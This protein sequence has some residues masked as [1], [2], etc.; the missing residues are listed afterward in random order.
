MSCV[1][2]SLQMSRELQEKAQTHLPLSTQATKG[3]EPTRG[4]RRSLK[5]NKGSAAQACIV[6]HRESKDKECLLLGKQ[7]DVPAYTTETV[8]LLTL[9][10]TTVV[11]LP[12]GITNGC[13]KSVTTTDERPE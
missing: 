4:R 11:T 1:S 10:N 12:D 8:R 6:K 5:A 3:R 7:K 2:S 13:Q 9:R